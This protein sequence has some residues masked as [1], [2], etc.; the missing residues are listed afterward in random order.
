MGAGA[1]AMLISTKPR[2][3][4]IELETCG[5]WTKE[6]GD[7]FRPTSRA[8]AG[9]TDSSLYCYLEALDGA[10]DHFRRRNPQIKH[11]DH[12]SR[13]IYHIPFGGM[14][15]RAHRVVCKELQSGM[16]KKQ[17]EQHWRERVLPSLTYT[18]QFGGLYGASTPIALIGSID[19]G[20]ELQGGDRVCIYAYGSG[21]NSEMY[22]IVLGP[23][24]KAIVAATNMQ[25]RLD[26]RFK[27][28]VE[29]YEAIEK[30]R[31]SYVDQETYAPSTDGI[32]GLYDS[33]YRGK[34]LLVFRGL[35]GY[36]R[37]YDWS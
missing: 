21:S 32:G 34:G 13:F 31:T 14:S 5:Y 1:V 25:A 3:A 16:K 30:E 33:H 23:E 20:K 17:I 10:Y 37:Q 19:T 35:Q 4:E 9:N 24:A 15:L 8:E 12:F 18:R 28:S 36:F 22:S 11:L 7:T 6:V 2:V 29:Q 26:E 27:L